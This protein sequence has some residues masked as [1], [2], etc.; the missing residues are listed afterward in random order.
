MKRQETSLGLR[1]LYFG[2]E[3]AALHDLFRVFGY[4]DSRCPEDSIDER[5]WDTTIC[6]AFPETRI[7]TTCR[8]W[9]LTPNINAAMKG[10][11]SALTWC[12]ETA[13]R[14]FELENA[15]KYITDNLQW[16]QVETVLKQNGYDSDWLAGR[17]DEFGLWVE[18]FYFNED[19]LSQ[20]YEAKKEDD[21]DEFGP[22]GRKETEECLMHNYD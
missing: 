6:A 18:C 14:T 9:V 3:I 13:I 15:I 12:D 4:Y 1:Q 5:H 20:T 16:E 7:K 8:P 2:I 11:E 21:D 19:A 10:I 17:K 22:G